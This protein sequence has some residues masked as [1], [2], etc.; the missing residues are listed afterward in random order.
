MNLLGSLFD[1]LGAAFA[2]VFIIYWACAGRIIIEK[3]KNWVFKIFFLAALLVFPVF[4]PLVIYA[5]YYRHVIPA[6]K[7]L[8]K[9]KTRNATPNS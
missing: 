8:F 6:I 4:T 7:N 9:H 5:I 3:E 1:I 2:I